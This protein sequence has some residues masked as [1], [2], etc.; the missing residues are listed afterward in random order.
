MNP[1][2]SF[3]PLILSFDLLEAVLQ[4]VIELRAERDQ[5]NRSD[6]YA[7]E[8]VILAAN[9]IAVTTWH[10]KSIHVMREVT[11]YNNIVQI[12][13]YTNSAQKKHIVY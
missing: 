3:E 13:D 7:E 11:I 2:V 5:V 9:G 1:Q 4:K 12:K 8:V 10:R 6:V